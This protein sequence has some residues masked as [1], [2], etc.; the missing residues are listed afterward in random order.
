M[1]LLKKCDADSR[2]PASL[3]K[4]QDS[5]GPARDADEANSSEIKP[6]R[7]RASKLTFIED[8][9]LEHSLPGPGK[10]IIAS[11]TLGFF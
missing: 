4:S 10:H 7:P 6:G 9:I 2:L 1:S 5:I 3:N 11:E 8:F